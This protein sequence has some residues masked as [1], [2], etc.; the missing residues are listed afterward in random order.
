M[1]RGYLAAELARRSLHMPIK[2]ASEFKS[3]LWTFFIILC[4]AYGMGA[5]RWSPYPSGQEVTVGLLFFIFF[6]LVEIGVVLERIA[7]PKNED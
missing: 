1:A 5:L 3:L 2:P 7:P 4:V 6:V